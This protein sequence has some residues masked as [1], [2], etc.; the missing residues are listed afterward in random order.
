M[1]HHGPLCIPNG[2]RVCL[3][4]PGGSI[5]SWSD[6]GRAGSNEIGPQLAPPPPTTLRAA[7]HAASPVIPPCLDQVALGADAKPGPHT[8]YIEGE[9]GGK[10]A[11]G[12]LDKERCPHFAL[13]ITL[14]ADAVKVSHSGKGAVYITGYKTTQVRQCTEARLAVWNSHGCC[15]SYCCCCYPH[16]RRRA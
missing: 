9:E 12:T 3:N 4:R 1:H 15:R 2:M 11:V 16:C 8:V 14:S 7:F 6:H 10:M 5:G 13:D